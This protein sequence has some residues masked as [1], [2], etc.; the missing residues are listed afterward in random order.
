MAVSTRVRILDPTVEPVEAHGVMAPR[1]A[2]LSGLRV[3]LLANGKRNADKLLD[4]VATLLA[5]RYRLAEVVA[6]NKG[7]ASRPAPRAIVEELLGRCD[8][9]VTATGD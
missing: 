3:G 5:E 4:A 2:D 8:V 1:P 7:D 6:R 9:V